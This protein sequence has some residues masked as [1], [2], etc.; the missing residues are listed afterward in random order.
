M[1]KPLALVHALQTGPQPPRLHAAY[2]AKQKWLR[3]QV[4][5]ALLCW[6]AAL[7]AG[8]PEQ[9]WLID[10][11]DSRDFPPT[12]EICTF[13]AP[14]ESPLVWP[15]GPQAQKTSSFDRT[16]ESVIRIV[17]R[18]HVVRRSDGSG[19]VDEALIAA[20]M[21][22]LNYGF[23]NTPFV[24]ARDPQI[25]YLD[26]D[27]WYQDF[28]TFQ[29][30]FDMIRENQVGG[31]MSW[32]VTPNINGAVAGTWIR[33]ASPYRG[34]LMAYSTIGNPANIVTPTHEM[35]HIF[36]VY[37]PFE[38]ALG[39]ECA[40]GR[41]CNSAGD[42]ICDTPASPRVSSS[43]TTAT[44]I[45]F[46]NQRGPCANDAIYAPNPR[47]YMDVG[48]DA[49]HIL[50]NEFSQGEMDRAVST[51][52]PFSQYSVADL[53]GPLRPEI[54]VDCDA[55][56]VDDIDEILR[57]EK[58]DLGQDLM[59]DVCQTFPRQGDLIVTGMGPTPNRLRYYDGSSGQWRGDLWNGMSFVH[60]ARTGP[61]GLVYLTR[62]NIVQRVSL[63][64]GR[65]VDNFIDGGREGARTFVDILFEPDGNILLLDN[66]TQNVR[67]YSGS[68]GRFMG[69]FFTIGAAGFAPKYMAYGP[70]GQIYIVG[71]GASGDRV[72]RHDARTGQFV[73]NF[74][75][76]GS[77]GLSAGQGLVFHDGYLYVANGPGRNVLR[78]EA[79]TGAF[80]RIFVDTTG[81]GGLNNPHSLRFGPDRNLYVAS[82]GTDSVKRY[83]GA[84]GAYIDDFVASR[85]GGSPGTGGLA[86]P[87]GILFAD[88]GEPAEPAISALMSGSWADFDAL[89]QGILLDV[90][91]DDGL[92][93]GG[94]VFGGWL[95]YDAA[96]PGDVDHQRWFSIQGVLPAAGSSVDLTI[97]LNQG[98]NLLAG[99]PTSAAAVGTATLNFDGCNAATLRYHF[100]NGFA[101]DGEILL[102]R[103]MD[104]SVCSD[105]TPGQ[106]A[107]SASYFDLAF[108]GQGLLIEVNPGSQAL[109]GTLFSYAP[110][111]QA[112]DADRHRWFSVQADLSTT[113]AAGAQ[114]VSA[115][116][117][118]LTGGVFDAPPAPTITPVGSATL[119]WES[120]GELSFSYAFSGG[121]AS[122]Q[123]GSHRLQRLGAL[124]AECG[125]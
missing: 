73:D 63:A 115:T 70:D 61:D 46:G 43:N 75:A 8:A 105:P 16:P 86:Q 55:N 90:I 33:P 68:D 85:A 7:V 45:Y 44:G 21:L 97:Y 14:T 78:F 69:V 84:S 51:L 48:W 65:T 53:V 118:E 117:Y 26:N 52:V 59:P 79:S 99:P 60:Q 92:G 25:V 82:R 20:M 64:T 110:A 74:V 91:E 101:E 37:H 66:V 80:D 42:L 58:A 107:L 87:A 38:T 29:S 34:I 104:A 125:I 10:V 1:T 32:Y 30:A 5:L 83:D 112:S 113:G 40:D 3:R 6:S 22:D 109:L 62:L 27:A 19:G 28:P 123:S 81:N 18:F 98:G 114:D 11:P 119:H 2:G 39:T 67:R 24:F 13:Q 111:G 49:G 95:T 41:N 120:C 9:P 71:N 17:N 57:G 31:I 56:G 106:F 89:G 72:L 50:R 54:L 4:G 116:L 36:Q 102:Q 23:R 93:Q 77:G 35:A 15:S 108:P 76:P 88:L 121:S 122:G 94:T 103:V 47:L 96:P 124:P 12:A 100:D